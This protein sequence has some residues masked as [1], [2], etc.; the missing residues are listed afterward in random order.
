VICGKQ[1]VDDDAN[2]TAQM[3]A[4]ML[5][6]P[7]AVCASNIEVTGAAAR[8]ETEVDGGRESLQLA[9]P[10][11]ISADLRLNEPRFASLG[12]IMRAKKKPLQT[13]TPQQLQVDVA[14]RL[15][16]L[17]VVEP[18]PRA[19]AA[20]LADGGELAAVIKQCI[21]EA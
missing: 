7:Q 14:P 6:W 16:T 10:A 17:A 12:D 8:V 19:G 18:A 5:G 21:A 11:L 13:L 9:L 2:Q 4:A 20:L 3:L 15:Q 1:A